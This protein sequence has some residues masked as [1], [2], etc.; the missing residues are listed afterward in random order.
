MKAVR[1]GTGHR[2]KFRPLSQA[3]ILSLACDYFISI[4][5]LAVRETSHIIGRRK[6]HDK[7]LLA[8]PPFFQCLMFS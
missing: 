4:S 6:K 1:T 7:N 3:N 2:V 5:T 8:L